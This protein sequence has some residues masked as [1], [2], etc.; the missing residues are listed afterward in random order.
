MK[1]FTYSISAK[2]RLAFEKRFHDDFAV[3][4][5]PVRGYRSLR[6]ML[7]IGFGVLIFCAIP[8]TERALLVFALSLFLFWGFQSANQTITSRYF[9]KF[10]E[11]LPDIEA[12]RTLLDD[13]YLTTENRRYRSGFPLSGAT[14]IFV[15]SEFVYVDFST[16]GRMR[17][18]LSAFP[19]D[20][21]LQEFKK[22]IQ[23]R[24]TSNIAEQGGGGNSAALRASP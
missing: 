13:E 18:P 12:Y 15:D 20:K 10:M 23:E 22:T 8:Q 17:V 19:D 6:A 21:A 24:I 11:R 3:L 2:D 7:A 9:L 4:W 14:S 5:A 1:D 16:L